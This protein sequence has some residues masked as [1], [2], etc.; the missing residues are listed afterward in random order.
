M[1]EQGGQIVMPEDRAASRFPLAEVTARADVALGYRLVHD[2]GFADMTDGFVAGRVFGTDDFIFGGYG[3]LPEEAAV[4]AL[5]RRALTPDPV[6]EKA[7][8][9]DVD[10][11]RFVQAIAQVRPGV[12]GVIHAHPRA[13][14]AFSATG[15]PLLPMSQWGLMFQGKL[16]VIPFDEDVTSPDALSL[17]TGAISK[18]A[19]AILL[20][21]HG[22]LTFGI[23]VADAF[24]RL[25][26]L[27]LACDLQL[28]AMATGCD[29][30]SM[31]TSHLDSW[32][33][34]YWHA[35]GLVDNDGSR[36]WG[37]FHAKYRRRQPDFLD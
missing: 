3:M 21:H 23:S 37:A 10:A 32:Q 12:G 9:V 30:L 1:P 16:G 20:Q 6:L 13:A 8:G 17:I 4:S 35:G 15:A 11:I 2:Y 7:G 26:R 19:E 24:F 28:R 14:I 22:L 36:E 33:R 31:P 18:G 29:I 34:E 5:H 27:D 25:H